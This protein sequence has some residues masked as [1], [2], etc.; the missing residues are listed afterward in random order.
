SFM[1]RAALGCDCEHEGPPVAFN[2]AK[3]VFIGKMLGGTEELAANDQN[4]KSYSIE[5]GEVRFAVEE[6]FKGNVGTQITLK[7]ASKKGTSCGPYGLK[8]G[9]RYIVYAYSGR[10]DA[11]GLYSGVCTRTAPAD[12]G[13]AKEDLDFLR[14]LPPAGTGGSITGSVWADLRVG[15]V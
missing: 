4:G 5:A 7:I 10:E 14:S 8:R 12:S 13:G 3:A 1:P 2:H 6:S 15:G 9:E 11:E